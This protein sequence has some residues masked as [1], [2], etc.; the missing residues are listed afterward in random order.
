MKSIK[1]FLLI[2]PAF[3][4]FN[5]ASSAKAAE[6]DIIKEWIKEDMGKET[7]DR[8]EKLSVQREG[9]KLEAA[10]FQVS[11]LYREAKELEKLKKYNEAMEK[12]QKILA[13]NPD[14]TKAQAYIEKIDKIQELSQER[15][16]EK[17]TTQKEKDRRK[18][19]RK[20]AREGAEAYRQ[21]K[22][23]QARQKW[24]EALKYDPDNIGI[25]EWVKRARLREVEEAKK[26]TLFE[27]ELEERAALAAVDKAYIPKSKIREKRKKAEAEE[28]I[29]EEAKKKL[30]EMLDTLK[31]GDLHLNDVDL[32]QVINLI[33]SRT[34]VTILVDWTAISEATGVSASVTPTSEEVIGE[35]GEVEEAAPRAA[36]GAI[37]TMHLDLDI[38]TPMPLKALLDYLMKITRLKYRVEE[39]AVL[40]STPKALE[41]E[42]MVVEVYK[43]KYGMSKLRPVTLKPLGAEED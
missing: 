24:E 41:K 35:E 5:P 40:I 6:K 23:S 28:E 38:Y 31:I 8:L 43:L 36:T 12:Y 13:L 39:H 29:K 33:T 30:E 27:K 2:F 34:K 16:L 10:K 19:F 14:E 22:Y 42:E 21:K 3:F 1:I 4:I 11:Q 15:A 9:A 32:R 7:I 20:F 18:K 17:A 25:K 37:K 26:E